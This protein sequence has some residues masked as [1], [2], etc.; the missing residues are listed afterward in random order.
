MPLLPKEVLRPGVYHTDEGVVRVTPK[1]IRRWAKQFGLMKTA[2]LSVPVPNE[3]QDTAKPVT[4]AQKKAAEVEHNAGFGE[5]MWVEKDGSLWTM[6]D[7]PD[8]KTAKHIV[9][10]VRYVSPEI[11][12]EFKDGDGRVWKDVITHMALTPRPV[13]QR[14]KPFG[15]PPPSALGQ[16]KAKFSMMRLSLARF[17][18]GCGYGGKRKMGVESKAEETELDDLAGEHGDKRMSEDSDDAPGG[19]DMDTVEGQMAEAMKLLPQ[20]NI[21]LPEHTTPETFLRD[22]CV[23]LHAVGMSQEKDKAEGDDEDMDEEALE[24][25]L[26]Q[27][28]PNALLMSLRSE[29]GEL[30]EQNAVLAAGRMADEL[31]R[32]AAEGRVSPADARSLKAQIEKKRL[33]LAK[34]GSGFA[35]RMRGTLD[36]IARTPRGTFAPMKRR[37]GSGDEP[38]RGTRGA[39]RMSHGRDRWD[40]APSSVTRE[41]GEEVAREQ[42]KNSGIKVD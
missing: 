29:V 8:E 10:N 28:Q 11:E 24:S 12:S 27:E 42:L 33:S 1:R 14:Q 35:A 17:N 38:P 26:E 21:H 40:E 20:H 25:E 6:L 37:A 13:F 19:G 32:Y 23:A 18:K 22:L 4:D 36:I 5:E 30:R 3:H 41:R 7:I 2:K 15:T 16:S 31:D 39:E 9:K 34:K